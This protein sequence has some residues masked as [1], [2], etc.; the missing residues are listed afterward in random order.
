MKSII[1]NKIGYK[2]FLAMARTDRQ[3]DI[4]NAKTSK[5]FIIYIKYLNSTHP[6]TMDIKDVDL[7]EDH[8]TCTSDQISNAISHIPYATFHTPLHSP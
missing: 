7:P 8:H 3:T 1:G 5:D 6:W 4:Y 2:Y